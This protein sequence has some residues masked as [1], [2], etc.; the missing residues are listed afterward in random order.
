[1]S[2][3]KNI[4]IEF[5][6]KTLLYTSIV[7]LLLAIVIF[8]FARFNSKNSENLLYI[9]QL[10]GNITSL[11]QENNNLET[12]LK[13]M[14]Q[15]Y[16]NLNQSYNS[17]TNEITPLFQ[18]IDFYNN[19]I[20]N[21]IG[22]FKD[23]SML[24]RS[25]TNQLWTMEDMDACFKEIGGKCYIKTA[26]FRLTNEIWMNLKY[27][28]SVE[29]S[30]QTRFQTLGE[31]LANGGGVC[32]DYSL[33]YKAEQNYLLQKCSDA[34]LSNIVINSWVYSTGS[35]TCADFGCTSYEISNAEEVS[36][37]DGYIY[38]NVVC[39]YIYDLSGHCVIAFTKNRIETKEDLRELDGAPMVEPQD[40]SYI[41]LI[42]DP[43][44]HVTLISKDNYNSRLRLFIYVVITD[45]DMFLFPLNNKTSFPD[46]L[47]YSTFGDELQTAKSEL[48]SMSR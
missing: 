16:N 48:M 24:N 13:T 1:M 12:S 4:E 30:N 2:G 7:I 42:N 3:K 25:D 33:F 22:W 20:K 45:K 44:S 27:K 19:E 31:F 11:N 14:N 8:Q 28:T 9:S 29:N 36:L 46:W 32:T 47:S 37:K 10:K 39:G 34:G 21:S 35:R 41:G 43:S 23:N 40:G 38:P 5:N 6:K 15:S 17:L 26:C 18:Q